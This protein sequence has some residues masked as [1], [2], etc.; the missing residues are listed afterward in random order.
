MKTALIAAVALVLAGCEIKEEH[1][2][3]AKTGLA[4]AASVYES[5]K[6]EYCA[7]ETE[8]EKAEFRAKYKLD[9]VRIGGYCE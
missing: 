3:T 6:D 8:E 4:V 1:Y 2:Q 5:K 7:L 9:E